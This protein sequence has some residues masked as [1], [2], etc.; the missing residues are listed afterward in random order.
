MRSSLVRGRPKVS[1]LVVTWNNEDDIDACIEGVLRQDEGDCEIELIVVDNASTDSTRV[2]LDSYGDKVNVL[3]QDS[4]R[5]FAAGMN[6]A[7]RAATGD[8]VLLLNPDCA[9]DEGC[10]RELR[11][12]LSA[13]PRLGLA[14]ARLRNLDGS[15]QPFAR[16][17]MTAVDIFWTLTDI[18][19]SLD[20][21]YRHGR[22]AARREYRAELTALAARA[23]AD[24]P[25][26]A[27][28]LVVD[29]PA[30][31]CVM[32][33]AELARDLDGALFDERFPLFFND[34]ELA[35]RLERKG[36]RAEVIPTATAAHG[37]GTSHRRLHRARRRA[38]FVASLWLW[39][40]MTMS[41]RERGLV[42]LFLVA[43][44]VAST[45]RWAWPIGPTARKKAFAN[46]RGVLGGLGLPYGAEP[47]LASVND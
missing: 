41:R 33:R 2:R 25:E 15:P 23:D 39:S 8:F 34:A 21:R 36:Y 29:H 27:A 16:R 5:G 42:W 18:G 11:R 4:N 35:R 37:Y 31:A 20:R 10:V 44:A 40:T 9:M 12:S 28:P 24:G 22:A 13:R 30:G 19:R 43:D 26:S 32:T 17:W 7:V 14:A 47:W 6:I 45:A 3:Q 38:E 1:V 46:A